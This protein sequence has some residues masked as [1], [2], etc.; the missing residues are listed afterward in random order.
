MG[1]IKTQTLM[2]RLCWCGMPAGH[3]AIRGANPA[4]PRGREE[5]KMEHTKGPHDGPWET[6]GT[7]GEE[8]VIC[9]RDKRG[10]RRTVAH[11]YGET[12]AERDA[13]ADLI[14]RAVNAHEGMLEALQA[15][16]QIGGDLTTER[17]TER[18]RPDDVIHHEWL[19]DRAV[20]RGMMYCEARRLARAAIGKA[21]PIA[22]GGPL[23]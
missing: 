20:A 6:P 23:K 16:A 12:E 2:T 1:K 3:T 5:E 4:D 22:V 15:I 8:R 17:L 10:K 21:E 7:D 11:V 18:D 13:R 14:V 9:Y 19:A